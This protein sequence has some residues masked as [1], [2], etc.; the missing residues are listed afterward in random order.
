MS[1]IPAASS[2]ETKLAVLS[3]L[4]ELGGIGTEDDL[5]EVL[6]VTYT[7]IESS[8]HH[9]LSNALIILSDQQGYVTRPFGKL[10]GG[11]TEARANWM[12]RHRP[13]Q[14]LQQVWEITASGR[15]WLGSSLR[16]DSRSPR[17]IES[18]SRTPTDY[19]DINAA[20]DHLQPPA[21]GVADWP[22]AE[23][24]EEIID[25]IE[26]ARARSQGYFGSP[27]ERKAIEEYAMTVATNHFRHEGYE[28]EVKGKPYDLRCR[29]GSEVLYVEVK[30]TTTDGKQVLLTP[31]EV[32]FAR[33]HTD[34]MALYVCS[35]IEL[36]RDGAKIEVLVGHSRLIQP[37]SIEEGVLKPV[38][39]TYSLPVSG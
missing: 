20:F 37:W 13:T 2:E 14:Q 5:R 31:N 28:V 24:L 29:R 3:G 38:G 33:E 23:D 17:D 35:G 6:R 30:G 10:K 11:D 27:E 15:D 32:Q 4:A 25:A 9:T 36:D 16:T 1:S 26:N 12:S 19:N 21:D 18:I 8:H 7:D 39:F 22:Q 34:R